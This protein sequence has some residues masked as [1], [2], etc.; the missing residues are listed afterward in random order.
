MKNSKKD[1]PDE[2]A[3]QVLKEKYPLDWLSALDLRKAF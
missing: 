3:I 1:L 2:D